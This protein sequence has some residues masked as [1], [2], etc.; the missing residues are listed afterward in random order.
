VGVWASGVAYGVVYAFSRGFDPLLLAASLAGALAAILLVDW[1]RYGWGWRRAA[2]VVLPGALLGF[3]ALSRLPWGAAVLAFEAA[4]L[5]ASLRLSGLWRVIA[6]GGLLGGVGGFVALSSPECNAMDALLPG[7]YLLMATG[8][9]GLRAVG[10]RVEP[11]AGFAGGLLLLAAAAL[12]Y[13][14]AGAPLVAL[15]L[16]ADVAS[17]VGGWMAGVYQGMRLRTYGFLEAFRTLTVMVAAALLN[18]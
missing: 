5:A 7:Y 8:F 4:M 11:L 2:A 13:L 12:H 10:V 9:S 16:A 15:V 17:R 18:G 1:A 14:F 6:G 3:V